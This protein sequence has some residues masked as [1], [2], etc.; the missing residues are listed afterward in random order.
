MAALVVAEAGRASDST[1]RDGIG[2]SKRDAGC[3]Q[4]A[5]ALVVFQQRPAAVAAGHVGA[6]EAAVGMIGIGIVEG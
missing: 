5:A 2:Q 4:P 1:S 3:G 6:L